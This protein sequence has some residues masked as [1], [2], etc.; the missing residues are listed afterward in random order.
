MHRKILDS[1]TEALGRVLRFEH[2]ADA[3]L[4]SYFREHPALGQSDRAF[5]AEA[6]F[7]VLRHKRVLDRVI[8][9]ANARRSLIGWL[10]RHSSLNA[11]DVKPLLKPAEVEAFDA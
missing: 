2:P 10:A 6:V 8:G 9:G 3:V 4:S 5:V 11:A 7:G 1:A